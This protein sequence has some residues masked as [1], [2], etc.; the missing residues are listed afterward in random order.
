MVSYLFHV[1]QKHRFGGQSG[2]LMFY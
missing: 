1:K 2:I